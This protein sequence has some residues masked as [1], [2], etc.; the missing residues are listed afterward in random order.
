M[1]NKKV[2]HHTCSLTFILHNRK[3]IEIQ[4]EYHRIDRFFCF[5]FKKMKCEVRFYSSLSHTT[6]KTLI[7]GVTDFFGG[8]LDV[9]DCSWWQ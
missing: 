2:T 6:K 7:N 9:I 5:T 8:V 3:I 4:I 1:I